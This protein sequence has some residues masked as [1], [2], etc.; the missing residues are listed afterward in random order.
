[1]GAT[2]KKK[3]ELDERTKNEEVRLKEEKKRAE[4]EAEGISEVVI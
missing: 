3:R 4:M 1:M 2:E